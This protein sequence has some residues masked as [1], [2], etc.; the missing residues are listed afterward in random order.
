MAF[1]GIWMLQDHCSIAIP[2]NAIEFHTEGFRFIHRKNTVISHSSRLL[3]G[4]PL[5]H[6][7]DHHQTIS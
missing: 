6:S 2:I 1:D 4:S 7:P 3:S 5:A